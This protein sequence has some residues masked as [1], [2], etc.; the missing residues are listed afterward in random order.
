[1]DD[2]I[3][4]DKEMTVAEIA[5]VLGPEEAMSFLSVMGTV[6]NII[7]HPEQIVGR[8]ALIAA[9]QLAAHRTKL[10]TFAQVYKTM[11]KTMTTTKRKNQLLSMYSALE[12]N[13]NT[14]KLLGRIE[15]KHL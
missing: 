6:Q 7:D 9:A 10:G 14:L 15:A 11:P 4:K 13:I 8:D 12:E 5:E 1:M 3:Q 2:V